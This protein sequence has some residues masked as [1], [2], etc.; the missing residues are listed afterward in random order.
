MLNIAQAISSIPLAQTHNSFISQPAVSPSDFGRPAL[1]LRSEVSSVGR[2]FSALRLL[3]FLEPVTAAV[4]GCDTGKPHHFPAEERAISASTAMRTRELLSGNPASGRLTV[5]W[6]VHGAPI[7]ILEAMPP[8]SARAL[9]HEVGR[10][11]LRELK[12]LESMNPLP[13]DLF[14]ENLT[15]DMT[16]DDLIRRTDPAIIQGFRGHLAG[17]LPDDPARLSEEQLR[18][19]YM[20]TAPDLFV[21]RHPNAVLRRS[22]EPE[23]RQALRPPS[24]AVDYASSH[25]NS[26]NRRRERWLVQRIKAL[27][28]DPDWSRSHPD[29]SA[30]V[31]LGAAHSSLCSAFFA[32]NFTPRI[33]SV[34]WRL[35]GRTHPVMS[36]VRNFLESLSPRC[37]AR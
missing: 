27:L 34:W 5:I 17:E 1:P 20:L 9:V 6:D 28:S 22:L 15:Q 32:E 12:Y 14:A 4:S 36:D 18:Y 2:C 25:S 31:F 8:D 26:M 10:Y 37:P 33:N 24:N 19:L 23:Q 16:Y 30:V 21:L 11:A 29:R 7:E 13:T 3:L 35:E